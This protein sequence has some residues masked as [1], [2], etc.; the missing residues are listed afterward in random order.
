MH[1]VLLPTALNY[2]PR[3][4]Q[5]CRGCLDGS[6]ILHGLS[7]G[8]EAWLRRL[9]IGRWSIL[10]LDYS[11]CYLAQTQPNR[12][13]LQLCTL[14]HKCNVNSAYCYNFSCQ[15]LSSKFY[16]LRFLHSTFFIIK[17]KSSNTNGFHCGIRNKEQSRNR[18]WS[19][20]CNW[21][22]NIPFS[23]LMEFR[24]VLNWKARRTRDYQRRMAVDRW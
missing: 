2:N 24:S 9:D 20:I 8:R 17:A 11:V 19:S 4:W 14:T 5:G 21:N 3:S 13:T 18:R 6:E 23:A 1:V 7:I 12:T 16:S 10:I 22:L 15:S